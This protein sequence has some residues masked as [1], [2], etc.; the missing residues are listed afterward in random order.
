VTDG[1]WNLPD[2]TDGAFTD[3][4]FRTGDVVRVDPDGYIVF[5]ERAKQLLVLSTGKNVAPAPIED[6]FATNR[7]V[8]QVMVLGDGRKFVSALVVPNVEAVRSWAS[9]A[10]LDLPDDRAA[11]CRDDRVRDRIGREVDRVNEQFESYERVKRF[12]LLPEAFSEEAGTLTPTL[13]KRRRS[14][15][16]VYADEVSM[17]YED[18]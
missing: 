2:E 10:G 8:E 14:I 9:E 1:Y 5:R 17:L 7:F 16:D 13:K 3:G 15:L 12:R 11:L 18:G 6:A 4:W